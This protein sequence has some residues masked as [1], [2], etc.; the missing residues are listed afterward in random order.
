MLFQHGG[1]RSLWPAIVFLP[2]YLIG[3]AYLIR[4]VLRPRKAD[5]PPPGRTG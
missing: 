3:L 1:Y 2:W 5:R 4:A